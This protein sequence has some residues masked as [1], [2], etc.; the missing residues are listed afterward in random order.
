MPI[1][2]LVLVVADAKGFYKR[3]LGNFD[4]AELPHPELAFFLLV[5]QFALAGNVAAVTFGRY[6]FA[7]GGNGFAR[8]DPTADGR[9]DRNFEQ[10][11]GN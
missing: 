8:N 11:S 6:V 1:E 9:L 3:R 10:M 7:Q 2:R 5:Q 4:L